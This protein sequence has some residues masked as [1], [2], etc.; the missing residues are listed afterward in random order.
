MQ[1]GILDFSLSMVNSQ[2]WKRRIFVEEYGIA[3]DWEV[4]RREI[5]RQNFVKKISKELT[6]I[7]LQWQ[8]DLV[9]RLSASHPSPMRNC[10]FDTSP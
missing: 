2:L 7:D 9:G 4:I 8:A 1:E 5:K 10:A 6:A 3:A